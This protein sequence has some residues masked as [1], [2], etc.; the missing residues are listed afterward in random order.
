MLNQRRVIERKTHGVFSLRKAAASW[1]KA[2]CST[3][4]FVGASFACFQ[5]KLFLYAAW[6]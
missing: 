6:L 1:L 3:Q 2:L 5:Y 4:L